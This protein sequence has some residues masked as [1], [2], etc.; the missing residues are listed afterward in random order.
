MTARLAAACVAVAIAGCGTAQ[1]AGLRRC[2]REPQ[3]HAA[4]DA[5]AM[6]LYAAGIAEQ[7]RLL[8]QQFGLLR[9]YLGQN[10]TMKGRLRLWNDMS[11]VIDWIDTT[12]AN[13]TPHRLENLGQ[14]G[15]SYKFGD[16]KTLAD[17]A[18]YALERGNMA[19]ERRKQAA[20]FRMAAKLQAR[21]IKLLGL[22]GAPGRK[23]L[24]AV[25]RA[26]RR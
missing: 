7:T 17:E 12:S 6:P 22:T 11:G 18:A 23:L 10:L 4:A 3:G 24:P 19:K 13:E 2:G 5:V 16:L 25:R 9:R 1:R 26:V 14:Q 8:H 20:A 15:F 21:G